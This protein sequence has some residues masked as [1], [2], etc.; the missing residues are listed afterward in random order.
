M[1]YADTILA[2]NPISAWLTRSGTR[3]VDAM[4]VGDMA[5][6]GTVTTIADPTPGI[7]QGA[8]YSA[9]AG[10][11][12]SAVA[13]PY[14]ALDDFTIELWLQWGAALTTNQQPYVFNAWN[15]GAAA[16]C[17][18]LT[19][20]GP[21]AGSYANSFGLLLST[22]GTSGTAV[23]GVPNSL[24][25]DGALHHVIARR[26]GSAVT[27]WVDGVSRASGTFAGRL[28]NATAAPVGVNSRNTAWGESVA[29][30]AIYA[31]GLPD[32][33]IAAHYAA[34]VTAAGQPRILTPGSTVGPG[35]SRIL[36][37]GSGR[38]GVIQ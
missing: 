22:N 34:G 7:A 6:S 30:P 31:A 36:S 33:R 26:I 12:Q 15:L 9:S 13:A 38:V 24:L 5:D 25:N 4:G 35:V 28:F 27:L 29:A 17:W 16:R 14:V 19:A 10:S 20:G 3:W 18:L 23:V 37:G 1:G 8:T 11:S 2:D 32:A 21:S